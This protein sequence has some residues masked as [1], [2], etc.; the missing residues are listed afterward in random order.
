MYGLGVSVDHV[1]AHSTFA[2]A[3]PS[4]ILPQMMEEFGFGEEVASLVVSIFIV[5]YCVGPL[6]WGPLSEQ[7]WIYS[8]IIPNHSEPIISIDWSE[9]CLLDLFPVLYGKF[10]SSRQRLQNSQ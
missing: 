3:A 7:V 5:G 9:T 4:T 10:M 2:S 1:M 6:L 8:S